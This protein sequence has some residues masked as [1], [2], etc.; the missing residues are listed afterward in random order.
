M[1]AIEWAVNKMPKTDDRQLPVMAISEIKKARTF[2][3]SFP[4]YS[5]TP[6][7]RL[8]HMAEY[9][10]LGEVYVKDESYRFGLNAFKVLGGSFAMARYIA[11]KTGKDV[12]ELPYS[13][14][15]SDQLREEFGQATFFT[16]TDGNHGRGV[17]WA[18]NKLRQKAVVFMPKGSTETR[19]KNI[20]KEN[21]IA[22]IE[23]VNYDECVRMAAAAAAKTPNGVV[24]QDTAWDG[25][26]E[27]PAWIMQGYGTMALEANEQLEGYGCDRPTHVFIQ[28]GVG[29][30]A[31]A[32]QGYFANRYP[33]NPPKV[34]VVEADVAACLYKGAKAGDGGIYIVDG[35]MQTIMAG[36]ACGE[37]N[38][39]SWDILKNHVDT[40]IAAP[41]WAAAK[42]MRM[43]AAPIK[44]DPQV[45][46][47]E[48]GAAP[49]GVLA[50][51]MLMDEYKELRE[52]LGLN[53][54]SKVL[55]FSTEGDTDPDRY[56]SIVWDGNER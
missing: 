48:S 40:F 35:D 53:K 19:L 33:E 27:I 45:T 32:V 7:A 2:H 54:D 15:T 47:G 21:A 38:T 16:A 1:K 49:F 10:G 46:S 23:E 52:H 5:E 8:D 51:I 55:L 30:L 42:G 18:A 50:C 43:L 13:V 31:G 14:L 36:L 12:S 56:K 11:Q 3:E 4:Q 28:A 26:E 39:I 22:T 6:L 24:V 41:D 34:V 44:G 25:Y 20:Q 17:A 9:L 29:S 37:P